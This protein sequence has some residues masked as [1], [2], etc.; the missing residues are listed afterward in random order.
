MKKQMYLFKITFILIIVSFFPLYLFAEESSNDEATKKD[1]LLLLDLLNRKR[2]YVVQEKLFRKS[3]KLEI[4]PLVGGFFNDPFWDTLTYGGEAFFHFSEFFAIGG[5]YRYAKTWQSNNA[6]PLE[7]V[8]D[9]R[10]D[11]SIL[12]YLVLGNII[13]TPI[14][15]KASL[16]ARKVVHFDFYFTLGAGLINTTAEWSE[17]V[18]DATG[19]RVVQ[20]S[21]DGSS[22]AYNF[23]VGARVF[24]T[25][26]IS[27]K[28]ELSN[29]LYQ[30]FV[31]DHETWFWRLPV[32][33]GFG[34]F[35]P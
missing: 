25:K 26:R 32:N 24:L 5:S 10:A 8:F 7:E 4:A 18:S 27:F 28:V 1:S 19:T 15:A 23:G 11:S 22:L 9:I 2:M 12:N 21:Q 30:D 6:K 31:R 29:V 35:L 13:I 17:E 3:P 33:V 34:I 14:Y 16:F 20:Q